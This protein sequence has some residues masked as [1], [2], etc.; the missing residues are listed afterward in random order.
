MI[1]TFTNYTIFANKKPSQKN[2]MYYFQLTR[3]QML[4]GL[5]RARN[6]VSVLMFWNAVQNMQETANTC[7]PTDRKV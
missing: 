6:N 1:N 3:T 7:F 2:R 4:L 5:I